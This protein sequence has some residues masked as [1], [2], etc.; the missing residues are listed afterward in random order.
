MKNHARTWVQQN[1]SS[2]A[3]WCPDGSTQAGSV[4]VR[5]LNQGLNFHDKTI[6]R[7]YTSRIVEGGLPARLTMANRRDERSRLLLSCRPEAGLRPLLVVLFGLDLYRL[8]AHSI[9]IYASGVGRWPNLLTSAAAHRKAIVEQVSFGYVPLPSP[10]D[11][12]GTRRF[13]PTKF[14]DRIRLP[15]IVWRSANLE[16][17]PSNGIPAGRY[18]LKT[19]NDSGTNLEVHNPLTP[20]QK[21]S[22]TNWLQTHSHGPTRI[23]GGGEWW[24][25]KIKPEIFLERA[26]AGKGDRLEEWKLH[27]MN[28]RCSFLY[29]REGDGARSDRAYGLRS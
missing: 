18:F 25:A 13:L 19:N 3:L 14:R 22:A 10:A 16:M 9:A 12:L 29:E 7:T 17:P 4:C 21:V 28:G 24:Y 11:K 5:V 8:A 27:V 20:N 1:R 15:E 6:E 23:V 2:F 26:I